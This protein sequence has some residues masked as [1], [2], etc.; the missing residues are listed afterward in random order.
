MRADT[1]QLWIPQTQ[2]AVSSLEFQAESATVTFGDPTEA[3]GAAPAPPGEGEDSL[4]YSHSPL[5]VPLFAEEALAAEPDAQG[6]S[7]A[8]AIRV[9][10]LIATQRANAP[11][12]GRGIIETIP[13]DNSRL[14][15]RRGEDLLN[16]IFAFKGFSLTIPA[17]GWPRLKRTDMTSAA[18]ILLE[19]PPQHLWETVFEK[20]VGCTRPG[21]DSQARLAR[22][23]RLAFSPKGNAW[24]TRE[25]TFDKLLDWSELDLVV[26]SR[27]KARLAEGIDAQLQ[28][29]GIERDHALE[30]V[31][32]KIRETF[33]PPTAQETAL[34]LASRLIFSPSENARWEQQERGNAPGTPL[35]NIR[36]DAVGRKSVRAIWSSYLKTNQFPSTIYGQ[37]PADELFV[38]P[39]VKLALSPTHHWDVVA[40][41][42]LYGLPALR[43]IAPD[44]ADATG[45]AVTKVPRANVVRPILDPRYLI[46]A[47]RLDCRAF[48]DT[49]ACRDQKNTGIAIAY[50]FDDA[51]ITLT[52]L[53]AIMHARWEGDPPHWRPL[54]ERASDL[55]LCLAALAQHRQADADHECPEQGKQSLAI[56]RLAQLGT[57][58]RTNHPRHREHAGAPPLHAAGTGMADQTGQRIDRDGDSGRADRG[59]RRPNTDDVYQKWHGQDRPASAD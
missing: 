55:N 13:L 6:A 56:E 59:M 51:D 43:S 3:D 36:L 11:F 38:D 50:P 45:A 40:Q 33:L 10:E 41:T 53:G 25:L 16:L 34:E 19:L 54:P 5:D 47:D 58:R 15:V 18:R 31:F 29:A 20:P 12:L 22:P 52:G 57:Q 42:S 32:G 7:V 49:A 23:S 9:P 1:H 30:Q 28:F 14:A 27:A 46:E 4:G 2:G 37:G 26:T 17:S 21:E 39:A 8:P 24:S 44:T 35:W 48:P